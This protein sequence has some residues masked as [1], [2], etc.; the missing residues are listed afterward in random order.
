ME[1]LQNLIPRRIVGL[2]VGNGVGSKLLQGYLDG[3]PELLMIPAYP[4]M[5]FYPHWE[6]WKQRHRDRWNWQTIVDLFCEKH[7]SVLD[8]RKIPGFNGLRTLG[9]NQNEYLAIDEGDFRQTLS[10]ILH[11]RPVN[12][13]DFLLGVHAAYALCRTEDLKK[14]TVLL[15]HLHNWQYLPYL[16]ED[17]P[18]VQVIAMTR[19]PRSNLPERI[20]TCY[21]VD[22]AKLNRTDA[23]LARALPS[24]NIPDY[25]YHDLCRIASLV[26][27][28]NLRV[29][30]HEDLGL[31]R[32]TTLKRLC[33]WIGL[34]YH[35]QIMETITFGGK[36]WWGDAIY[37]MPP[38]KGFYT[39]VLD[40]H[41]KQEQS[42]LDLFVF[43]G[44]MADFL[45]QYGYPRTTS[46]ADSMRNRLLL[47]A[48]LFVPAAHEWALL[49]FYFN[50]TQ[51]RC[52]LE[53][54]WKETRGILPREDYQTNA[55]HR[56]KW[57]YKKLQLGKTRLH[58]RVLAKNPT[59]TLRQGVYVLGQ[60]LRAVFAALLFPVWYVRIRA[61]AIRRLRERIAN[62]SPWPSLI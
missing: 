52:F 3:T 27:K 24:F 56:F 38:T 33:A 45:D 44:L 51:W 48:A 57:M 20:R 8:S 31:N 6:D 10:S 21:N 59:N 13:R 18:E 34:P 41:W 16:L 50:P 49:R 55:T 53:N 22:E 5:Y 29:L 11:A 35:A 14:K 7:A 47:W 23:F 58:V 62:T 37:N 46:R 43:E 25:I 60:T 17:F 40:T 15:Y 9:T 36:Q 4:L 12:R 39:K 32:P 61:T 26:P 2:V 30:R 28:E 42:V 54:C 1:P 19:D